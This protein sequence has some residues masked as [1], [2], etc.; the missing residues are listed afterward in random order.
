MQTKILISVKTYPTLSSKYDELVCTAGFKED[1]SWVRLYPVPFRKLDY[2]KQYKKW[3]WIEA[4]IVKNRSDFRPESYKLR[5]ISSDIVVGDKLGTENN[6]AKRKGIVL[7]NIHTNLENLIAEAKNDK[8]KTSLATLKPKEVID[9][10]WEETVREWNKD[11]L[12]AIYANQRQLNLFEPTQKLFQVA[13]KLPYKFS[14]TFT[15]EDGKERTLMIE[16][17][18]LGQLF[19]NSFKSSNGDE[20]L[21]CQKVKQK[22]FDEFV[23]KKDLYFFLGTTKQFHNKGDN[24]FIIIGTFYPNKEKQQPTLF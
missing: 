14:Y 24:P 13:K 8:L 15:T 11:K 5:D 23:K 10:V 2:Q 21:A 4:D 20:T 7:N 1:G 16:D 18:E 22:Y 6:W 12:N 9:F 17:W 3:Q 19:W